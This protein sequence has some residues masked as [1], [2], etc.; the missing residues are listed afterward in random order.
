MVNRRPSGQAANV[1]NAVISLQKLLSSNAANDVL[2]PTVGQARIADLSS[3]NAVSFHRSAQRN[4]FRDRRERL[5]QRSFAPREPT[6]A[7]QPQLQPALLRLSAISLH[8]LPN[9]SRT[10]LDD[11][12]VLD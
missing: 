1:K 10:F 2:Q 7:T 11:F 5:Q 12:A 3:T 8:T 4:A 9:T 6:V